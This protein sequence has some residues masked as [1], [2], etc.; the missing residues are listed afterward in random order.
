MS[1]T[2]RPL[3]DYLV[4]IFVNAPVRLDLRPLRHGHPRHGITEMVRDACGHGEAVL[5]ERCVAYVRGAAGTSDLRQYERS[6]WARTNRDSV[7]NVLDRAWRA[8]RAAGE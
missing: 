3:H 4:E 5:I 6:G 7:I 1:T 2:D 8:A